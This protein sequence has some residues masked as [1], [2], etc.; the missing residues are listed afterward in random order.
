MKSFLQSYDT[1][2]FDMDG[3]ITCEMGYWQSAAATVVEILTGEST[4]HI[5]SNLKDLCNRVFHQLETIR[6]AKHTG[7]NTNWDLAYVTVCL[8]R[9]ARFLHP[10]YTLDDCFQYVYT[11]F[12]DTSLQATEIYADCSDK[13][14]Q[15]LPRQD[16]Y[17]EHQKEFWHLLQ[18]MF[19]Q[20]SLGD[21]LY[22]EIY[23]RKPTTYGHNGIILQEDPL[24]PLD[25]IHSLLQALQASGKQLGIGTGRPWFELEPSLRRWDLLSYFDPD[26]L[27]TYSDVYQ[28][29]I[30][31]A[32]QGISCTL[33]KPHPYMFLKGVLGK[34][35]PD[36]K[37]IQGDY[38]PA[39][40]KKTLVVGDAGSD[41]LSAHAAGM[42]F[43]AVL[44]GP[45]GE[46]GRTFFE[47]KQAEYILPTVLDLL[48]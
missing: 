48:N 24:F 20:W 17:W 44:T 36:E 40:C 10:S 23:H 7:I 15:A 2:L 46:N 43:L 41:I 12:S 3:V 35:Y 27:V 9:Y 39:P 37:I 22:E 21:D 18:D 13:I 25:E 8:C 33:S 1:I 28:A 26:A 47:Q 38:D 11:Y 16:A 42:D 6:A 19:Q 4:E 30:D 32:E 29:Q 45:E 31:L 14:N 34:S 5:A